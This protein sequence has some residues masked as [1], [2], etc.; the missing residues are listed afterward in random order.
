M[1]RAKAEKSIKGRP[2]KFRVR[3]RLLLLGK[4]RATESGFNFV[5]LEDARKHY[6]DM[7]LSLYR[8]KDVASFTIILNRKRDAKWESPI[9]SETVFASEK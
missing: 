6:K 2:Y 4:P 8:R 5:R 3:W 1:G 9:H 7:L